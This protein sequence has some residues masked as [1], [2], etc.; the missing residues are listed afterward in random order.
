MNKV[1]A[2]NSIKFKHPSIDG[3]SITFQDVIK[4]LI[5]VDH[6]AEDKEMGMRN[7]WADEFML[8][9]MEMLK[10][11]MPAAHANR[12]DKTVCLAGLK[13]EDGEVFGAICT[14]VSGWFS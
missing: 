1:S 7:I 2:Y 9:N 6:N 5:E 11:A 10:A 13:L 4:N 14:W 12:F 3:K 8:T